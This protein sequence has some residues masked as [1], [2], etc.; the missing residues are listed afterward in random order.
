MK[1]AAPTRYVLALLLLL[2]PAPALSQADGD[3]VTLGTWRVLHSDVLGEDRL[4]QVHL[5]TG[6][7]SEGLSYPVVYVFY[8][9]WVEGYF[10]QL[11]NDLYH[12]SMDRMPP[13]TDA[14]QPRPPAP[15][16]R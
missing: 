13:A 1:H 7:D 14:A 16:P 2:A 12:L 3:P 5:P 10:A 4:L 6:Y 15:V 9:D 8:S 11:V